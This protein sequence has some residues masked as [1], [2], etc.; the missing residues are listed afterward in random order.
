MSS[1]DV[2]IRA[3]ASMARSPFKFEPDSNWRLAEDVIKGQQV[4]AY[5]LVYRKPGEV[6]R[7]KK[8]SAPEH[9]SKSKLSE[10]WK[11]IAFS[12]KLALRVLT[13][14]AYS[15]DQALKE[16]QDA[17]RKETQEQAEIIASDDRI[18]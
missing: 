3:P 12:E 9:F 2:P 17:E 10:A 15:L 4:M 6:G 1:A 5:A 8:G 14:P 13:E 11:V 18:R 16:V 7:G